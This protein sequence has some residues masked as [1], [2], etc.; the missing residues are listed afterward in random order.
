M[1]WIIT[2]VCAAWLVLVGGA[3][4]ECL[5]APDLA[6]FQSVT[7][8][9]YAQGPTHLDR[10][11][12][13]VVPVRVNDQGPFRFIVDTGANRS[14]ISQGLATQ[15]GLAPQG[16]GAVHNVYGVTDAP[17]VAVNSLQFGALGFQSA[18]MPVL[19]GAMMAG[20]RGL[21]GADGM[22][23]R[24]LL[25]DFQRNCIEILTSRG[26]PRL[27]NYTTVRGALR[28]GHLVVIRG[29]VGRLP[30]T[31]FI[32]TGSNTTLANL[33]LRDRLRERADAREQAVDPVRIYTAGGAVVLDTG[34]AIPRVDMGNVIVGGVFA[35]VGDFHIFRLWDLD[36]EPAILVGM[37]V[38]ARA[39]AVA[40]DYERATVH[41]R[42]DE[43]VRTGSRL[44]GGG[45]PNVTI[46]N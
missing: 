29:R 44:P 28:F 6:A 40:I 16:I 22:S 15:L 8:E 43:P 10:L 17:L 39:H 45:G 2:C 4:A 3:W 32:D 31:M 13:V 41:F 12:R 26:A 7:P 25:L 19:D 35:Y 1:R 27:R 18:A 11:G 42:L 38:L 23:G 20:E 5:E 46:R 34:I 9:D 33:A 36:D 24:R 21:L 30:V 37:D 14:A